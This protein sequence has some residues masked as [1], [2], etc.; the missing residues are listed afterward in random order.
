MRNKKMNFLYSLMALFI[1]SFAILACNNGSAE[2]EKKAEDTAKKT[3]QTPP[4][5]TPDSLGKKDTLNDKP[6]E[7]SN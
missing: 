6:T 1:F 2:S 7:T 5:S 4:P 3:E